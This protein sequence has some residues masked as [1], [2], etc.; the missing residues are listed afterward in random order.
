[1]DQGARLIWISVILGERLQCRNIY[2][3]ALLRFRF[4]FCI[5]I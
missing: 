2:R 5:D 1:M 3:E 4:L